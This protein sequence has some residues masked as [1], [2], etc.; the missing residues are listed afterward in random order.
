[1]V[2]IKKKIEKNRERAKR[3]SISNIT[4]LSPSS[5]TFSLSPFFPLFRSSLSFNTYSLSFPPSLVP[6][7]PFSLSFPPF[8]LPFLTFISRSLRHLSFAL[9]SFS[10]TPNL[11]PFSS[12]S[13]NTSP[14]LFSP[15]LQRLISLPFPS[16]FLP[17]FRSSLSSLRQS[18]RRLLLGR[19]HDYGIQE[20]HFCFR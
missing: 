3:S 15:F 18:R 5:T 8:P 16:F 17:F 9:L 13:F 7:P 4:S 2:L 1:M 20:F 12:L 6:F 14:S 10:P 19:R 11:P